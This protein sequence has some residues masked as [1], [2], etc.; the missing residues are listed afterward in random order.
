MNVPVTNNVYV[1]FIQQLLQKFFGNIEIA[2]SSIQSYKVRV[3][4]EKMSDFWMHFNKKE[5]F[6]CK[7]NVSC[8]RYKSNQPPEAFLE[9]K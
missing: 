1:V 2:L 5:V 8:A 7:I 9:K 4:S 6:S 3:S